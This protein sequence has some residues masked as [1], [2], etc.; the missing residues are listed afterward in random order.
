MQRTWQL[1]LLVGLV[2]LG[3]RWFSGVQADE[4]PQAANEG[5]TRVALVDMQRLFK[6]YP[7][8]AELR[9]DLKKRIDSEDARLKQRVEDA[10][11]LV[12][13]AKDLPAASPERKKL[14]MEIQTLSKEIQAENTKLAAEFLQ[15]EAEIYNASYRT[16][17]AEVVRYAESRGIQL[18]LRFIEAEDKEGEKPN[19]VLQK[20]QA[21]VIYHA[22]LDITDEVLANLR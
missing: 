21:Q 18:V 11:A 1:V 2:A 13:E 10:K 17:R 16:I 19:E 9:D 3:S 5:P 15:A 7:R 20:L 4:K 14:E 8:F 6:N 12:A 22:G